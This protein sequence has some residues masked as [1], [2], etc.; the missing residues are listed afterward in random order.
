MYRYMEYV[1]ITGAS[2]DNLG[3]ESMTCIAIEE[4]E[5]LA[6]DCKI[7]LASTDKRGMQKFINYD[8]HSYTFPLSLENYKHSVIGKIIKKR[9]STN[10]DVYYNKILPNT[11]YIIDISG[12]AFTT[13]FGMN[14][15]YEYLNRI[16]VAK[17][18]KIKVIIMS[19]SFG[20]I[21]YTSFIEKITTNFL[22]KYIFK[23]PLLVVAREKRGYDFMRKYI[24]NNLVYKPDMVLLYQD[25][26]DYKKLRRL[27][28][29]H[30]KD[31]V[32]AQ[33]KV[34]IIPNQKIIE[35]TKIGNK[36]IEILLKII[37][38]LKD[39]KIDAELIVHCGL[40]KE[41]C[42]QILNQ[43]NDNINIVDCTEYGAGMFDVIVNQYQFII[44][45]RYHAIVHAYRKRIPAL[46]MGW[47]NKYN[48]LLEMMNQK[49]YMFDCREY[50]DER[51]VYETLER[52]LA[53]FENEKN[54]LE[55]KLKEI[56]E[57]YR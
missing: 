26:I 39:K 10:Y 18:Y 16:Y 56:Y 40:D 44:A 28:Y 4:A 37:S 24:K 12:Y 41:I 19:Q 31:E 45:S 54:N 36:Y 38:I 55:D 20:P 27:T 33:K 49:E 50:I 47:E 5:R 3:A 13:K 17:C 42:N 8:V 32:T 21:M 6:P 53:E 25:D 48:E 22:I 34:G 1:I 57:K 43:C 23:Y 51:N 30:S 2:I 46:V 15:I 9:I 29:E 52:L 7:I 11:R 35:K 14:S